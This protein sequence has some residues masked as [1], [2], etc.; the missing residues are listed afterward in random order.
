MEILP[1]CVCKSI[2][3]VR[4]KLLLAHRDPRRLCHRTDHLGFGEVEFRWPPKA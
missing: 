3:L 2:T 1:G 4:F